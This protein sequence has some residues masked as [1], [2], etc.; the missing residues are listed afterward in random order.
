MQRTVK[1]AAA[2]LLAEEVQYL[3]EHGDK[4]LSRRCDSMEA[5]CRNQ[6]GKHR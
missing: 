4:V 5:P 6:H 2:V 3:S 1:L